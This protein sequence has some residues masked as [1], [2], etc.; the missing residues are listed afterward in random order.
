M[1]DYLVCS[2]TAVYRIDARTCRI[3]GK[4]SM[5]SF[6]DLHG[7]TVHEQRLY[8]VNTG[9]DCIDVFDID[10][11]FVGTHG[12][13][14]AWLAAERQR[15][16]YPSRTHWIALRQRGWH[17]R[18]DAV[19]A[20]EQL[21]SY[22]SQDTAQPFHKRKVRDYVHPNH[23]CFLHGR[24][25]VTSLTRCAIIDLHTW[26]TVIELSTPPHDGQV[27]GEQLWLTLVDGHIECYERLGD[28]YERIHRFDIT[29]M[30]DV[31]GW[32]RGLYVTDDIV[33]VGFT[34]IR[35]PPRTP[36]TRGPMDATRTAVVVIDRAR[37]RRMRLF[38]LRDNGRHSKVFT[39]SKA[40][41]HS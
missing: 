10:G 39:L 6:N 4:L 15:G 3:T 24:P 27:V 11:R 14:C 36:W 35:R 37:Q 1:R 23:I 34:E 17:E 31:S 28:R 33:A 5:P 13:E 30:T 22:Y 2:S 41:V 26:E 8:V 25:L 19:V 20:D 12:F 7:I 29:L 18:S 21:G 32:C 16:V 9:L 38:D 40:P